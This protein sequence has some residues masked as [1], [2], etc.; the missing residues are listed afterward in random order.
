MF[1]EKGHIRTIFLHA[2][3][4]NFIKCL[5]SCTTNQKTEGRQGFSSSTR[6]QTF[7][8]KAETPAVLCQSAHVQGPALLPLE[9]AGDGGIASLSHTWEGQ[10]ELLA[11]AFGLSPRNS[12]LFFH[13]G[14]LIPHGIQLPVDVPAESSGSWP[15]CLKTCCSSGKLR[16]SSRLLD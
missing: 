12:P 2:H 14:T 4:F 13:S 3:V 1:E 16:C 10:I 6:R 11:P 15:R 9:A 5:Q 7:Q 8:L